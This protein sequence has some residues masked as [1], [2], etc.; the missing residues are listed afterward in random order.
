MNPSRV[1]LAALLV[2]LCSAL[3][4]A[5]APIPTMS[6]G[7]NFTSSTFFVNSQATPPDSNGAIGPRHFVE[8]IN[9]SFAVY[10]KT[11]GQN[12]KRVTDLHF[13][14]TAGVSLSTDSAVT[15]PRIIY[16][17]TVQRWFASMVDFD[18]NAPVDPSLESNDFLLGVSATSD[19]TGAWHGFLFQADPDTGY[20]A[21]FPTLGV[22]S[23]AVYLSGDLYHGETNPI[24]AALVSF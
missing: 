14:S 1:R 5:A 4:G 8:F 17:P 13:W 21:D 12:V 9:G 20:F 24:G 10:N 11:N 22:D 18:A 6:I 7:Q 2:S 16:D 3:R 15:D 23:N 19:P